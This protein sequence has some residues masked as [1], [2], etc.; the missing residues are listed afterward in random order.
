VPKPEKLSSSNKPTRISAC[1]F[2]QC[3]D[4]YQKYRR[5][6]YSLEV[7]V[8]GRRWTGPSTGSGECRSPASQGEIRNRVGHRMAE[9]LPGFS[10]GAG[11]H[12]RAKDTKRG[13]TAVLDGLVRMCEFQQAGLSVLAIAFSAAFLASGALNQLTIW[14]TCAR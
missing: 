14:T 3:G 5:R 9:W 2:L 12:W 6:E 4:A 8:T 13:N 7:I 11:T 1:A 10:P